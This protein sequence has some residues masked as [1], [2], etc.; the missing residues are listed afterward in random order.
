M[1]EPDALSRYLNNQTA[2]KP[3]FQSGGLYGTLDPAIAGSI[4]NSGGTVPASYS[5]QPATGSSTS[6]SSTS[7]SSGP[8][9]NTIANDWYKAFFSNYGVP[10]DVQSN[11]IDI[12]KK[13]ASDPSTA[14]ALSTQYLRS[15]PWYQTTFPGFNAGV[16]N[17][18]FSDEAGYRNYLNAVNNVYNQYMGRHVSGDEVNALL[19][20]G[21]DPSTLARRFAGQAYINTNKNEIQYLAGAFGEG[22]L[23]PDQ[24]TALGNENAGIDTQQGQLQQR[25]QAKAQQVYSKLFQ[26]SLATPNLSLGQNGLNAPSLGG[27]RQTPDIAA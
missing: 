18:M 1:A 20:E 6:S 8:D 5:P 10:A 27:A 19:K 12:L 13:Y 24:L 3:A 9:A 25:I 11:L 14:Q 22:R 21:A 15:T 4:V 26:G 7:G 17:G 2:P 23:T 16:S